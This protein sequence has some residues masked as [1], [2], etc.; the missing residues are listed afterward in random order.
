MTKKKDKKWIQNASASI[1][2]RGTKGVCTGDKF[3][4]STCPPG[5]KRYNLAKVFKGM[6]R[7]KKKAATGAMIHAKTSAFAAN[8]DAWKTA[9]G[10]STTGMKVAGA[11]TAY[12]S[13]GWTT[14]INKGLNKL[15]DMMKL[16]TK[17]TSMAAASKFKGANPSKFLSRAKT[18]STGFGK[19]S[20]ALAGGPIGIGM[21]AGTMGAKAAVTHAFKGYKK[22]GKWTKE[23]TKK[24][25]SQARKREALLAK[26]NKARGYK[27]G[28]EIVTPSHMQVWRPKPTD[29]AGVPF[30][31]VPLDKYT[32]DLL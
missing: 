13:P 6:A 27:G 7:K 29:S 26:R 4:G 19:R 17:S 14:K 23:G 3:G 20:V 31:P 10:A 32:K 1:K 5:S 22:D 15:K 24:L 8:P 30:E 18:L 2:K 12:T 9:R 16:G 25:E 11:G 28:A 21:Y